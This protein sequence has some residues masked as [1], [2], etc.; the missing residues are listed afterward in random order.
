MISTDPVAPVA[1]ASVSPYLNFA[2]IGGLSADG[3]LPGALHIPL[4]GGTKDT[5]FMF[6]AARAPGFVEWLGGAGLAL[7]CLFQGEARENLADVAPWIVKLSP[8]DA[9]ITALFSEG[10]PMLMQLWGAKA[11]IFLRSANGMERVKA[12]LRRLLKVRN[13]DDAWTYFR[14]WDPVVA[15]DY[16]AQITDWPERVASMFTSRHLNDLEILA[17]DEAAGLARHFMPAAPL[18]DNLTSAG[19][20]SNVLRL[21]PRDHQLFAARQRPKLK[22]ELAEWLVRYDPKRFKPF[23]EERLAAIAEHGL[24]QGAT[25]GFEFKEEYA[26]LLYMMSF[27]GG[28]FHTSSDF[29]AFYEPWAQKQDRRYE[30]MRLGFVQ[31]FET[32]Y[33]ASDTRDALLT[34]IHQRAAF[35]PGGIERAGPADIETLSGLAEQL[36]PAGISPNAARAET[37]ATCKMLGLNDTRVKCLFYMLRL[38]LGPKPLDDPFQ[39]WIREKLIA[40]GQRP[41]NVAKTAEFAL[42]RLRHFI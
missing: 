42:R 37:I 22:A 35:V 39:P 23:G 30:T 34:S 13:A 40:S 32:A 38:T 29:A 28:W 4:F 18:P 14:F 9:A 5:Y 12:H 6:D 19:A 7:D 16:F 27:L 17:I 25:F 33:P 15:C 21:T 36:L 2:E 11:G 31:A 41:T 8:E 26:H 10:E 3:A 24:V 20:G 1:G